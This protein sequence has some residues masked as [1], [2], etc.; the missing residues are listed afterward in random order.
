MRTA[1]NL[2]TLALFA[3]AI[4]TA[5]VVPTD[6][7]ITVPPTTTEILISLPTPPPSDLPTNEPN[8]T[9]TLLPNTSAGNWTEAETTAETT[10]PAITDPAGSTIVDGNETLGTTA[11][12][13]DKPCTGWCHVGNSA[14]G[15]LTVAGAAVGALVAALGA[16]LV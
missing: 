12:E 2:A 14:P 4:A 6:E 10:L 9:Y 11:A 8:L 3:A 7:E 5:Q 1:K 15:A 16:L 13:T